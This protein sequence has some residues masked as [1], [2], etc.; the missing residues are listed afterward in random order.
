MRINLYRAKIDD[1]NIYRSTPKGY[2]FGERYWYFAYILYEIILSVHQ[3][4]YRGKPT[5]IRGEFV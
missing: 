1:R 3:R 5:I 4:Y 2:T